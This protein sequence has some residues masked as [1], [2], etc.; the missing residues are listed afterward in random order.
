MSCNDKFRRP[1]IGLLALSSRRFKALG[2]GTASGRYD[3]RITSESAQ[4]INALCEEVELVFPCEV[5]DQES[6]KFA[7]KSL[8]LEEVDGILVFFHSWAEDNVWSRFLRDHAG[9]TPLIYYHPAKSRISYENCDDE[10][11]FVQ[12]LT[13]GGLVG[14][15]VGSGSLKRFG[16]E[17]R[18]ISG[19][20]DSA[21]DRIIDHAK[22][23]RLRTILRSSTFAIMPTYNEIM[24]S[25]YID[26]HRLFSYGPE[27][28]FISYR[29]LFEVGEG[30]PEEKI[31]E[32][33]EDLIQK[34]PLYDEID[35]RKFDASLRYSLALEQLMES[36]G[37]DAL[38]LNDVSSRIFEEIGLR[39]GFY[40][41]SINENRSI[42]CPEGDLGL[43]FAQYLLKQLSSEQVNTIEPFYVDES[44]DLF[45]AGHA[46]PN[47]YT[48]PSSRDH[49]KIAVDARF[50]KSPY[51]YA[52]APFA[53]LRIPPGKMTML[54]ISEIDGTFKMVIALIESLEGEHMINGYAHG[55]F[56]PVGSEVN[57]FFEKILKVGTTQHF[58][59]V[60]GDLRSILHEFGNLC[61]FECHMI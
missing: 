58:A 37:I 61:G 23:C 19:S 32:W 27:L 55:E 50:A 15:L 45:C 20:I 24:W 1:K 41:E 25:T 35:E 53:W 11:D 34:Y 43:A 42:L 56:R 18:I 2:E 51:K 7:V 6:L 17:A 36:Y 39:P 8:T 26:P 10:N 12:F 31:A 52:G 44:K 29:E 59:V 28:R 9:D 57:S 22:A 54:H 30:I 46:G 16:K 38:T 48:H 5:N 14:M 40:P 47:D 49:V 4:I 13:D 60:P 3:E 21:K 33:K